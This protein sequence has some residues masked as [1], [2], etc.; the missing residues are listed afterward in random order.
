MFAVIIPPKRR[1]V[2]LKRADR[3]TKRFLTCSF[4]AAVAA[5]CVLSMSAR[6]PARQGDKSETVTVFLTGNEH[7]AL[8]PC[9]CSGGQLGGLDRRGAI[10]NSVAVSKRMAVDTGSFVKS[11]DEQDLIKFDILMEAYNRLDYDA[12]NLTEKDVETARNSGLL[13]GGGLGF[14]LISAQEL[15][16]VNLSPSF[17]KN[18]PL[19][20]RDVAVTVASFDALSVPAEQVAELF[21]R[22]PGPDTFNILILN[23]CDKSAMS[24]ILRTGIADCIICPSESDEPDLRSKPGDR[25]LVLSV[26]RYGKYVTRLQIGPGRSDERPKLAFSYVPVTEDLLPDDSLV[27]LYEAYQQFVRDA[28][29][30]EKNPR[31]PLP[32]GLEYVGSQF[33]KACH[34]H[35]YNY[36]KWSTKRHADAYATLEKVGSQYGP[37]CIVCHVVGY[38]YETGYVSEEKTPH[39]KDVGCENC[40]GPGSQHIKSLGREKTTQPM[41]DCMD[42]HT[43]E[44]SGGFAGHEQEYLEKIV[45]W[46]PNAPGNVK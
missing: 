27:E 9:G 1:S 5:S 25:P 10:L 14:K 42:C 23:T 33:C 17:T 8:K 13:D 44:H 21:A 19:T 36:E 40:H 29:L 32:N 38:E 22:R 3:F 43:P 7:G 16:D 6:P 20:G 28:D 37:E 2:E 11:D 41:S 26:G 39:L 24:S 12:V 34:T 35:P 4:L 45:H 46:E 18:L 30:L 31:L 15:P